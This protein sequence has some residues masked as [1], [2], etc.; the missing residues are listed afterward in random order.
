MHRWSFAVLDLVFQIRHS[1]SYS[2]QRVTGDAEKGPFAAPVEWLP[3]L[4]GATGGDDI[5][6]AG[7]CV[8]DGGSPQA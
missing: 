7:I 6:M 3:Q 4:P 2:C 1:R 5:G 8:A